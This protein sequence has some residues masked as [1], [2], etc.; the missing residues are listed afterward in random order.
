MS[1]YDWMSLFER[2]KQVADKNM[3]VLEIG[4]SN[5][6]RTK[7]LN[8]HCQKLIGVE[9]LREPP[10]DF[11]NV[12]YITGDWQHLSEFIDPESIDIA[13]SSHVLEHIPDDLRAINELYEVLKPGGM[14]LLNT[15]NRRRLVRVV[16]EFFRGKRKF[17]RWEHQREAQSSK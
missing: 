10:M 2:Y 5:L 17:P 9:Y 6:C 12:H 8:Q 14:A 16:I 13:V 11:E 1:D 4:A 3:V 7:D 15:Q